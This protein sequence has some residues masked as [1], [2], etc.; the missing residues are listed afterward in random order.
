MTKSFNRTISLHRVT[1][2]SAVCRYIIILLTEFNYQPPRCWLSLYRL[3]TDRTDNTASI[4]G[5]I[6]LPLD[7][8]AINVLLLRASVLWDVFTHPL[9]SKGLP[10]VSC[11]SDSIG[12]VYLV[13]QT[14]YTY[15]LHNLIY[16]LNTSTCKIYIFSRHL[17]FLKLPH[18]SEIRINSIDF[19]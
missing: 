15:L 7:C 4:V 14:R 11:Y 17:E 16:T 12:N 3:H 5:E 9:P 19:L 13:Y 18:N 8:L 1:Y 6:C 10:L 2:N